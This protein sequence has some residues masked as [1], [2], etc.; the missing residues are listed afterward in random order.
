MQSCLFFLQGRS[1][2]N[3][4]I[5]DYLTVSTNGGR[6]W[7]RRHFEVHEGGVLFSFRGKEVNNDVY[8]RVINLATCSVDRKPFNF[9]DL[10][11]TPNVNECF[12]NIDYGNFLQDISPVCSVPLFMCKV[13]MNLSSATRTYDYLA[14]S[15]SGKYNQR[16]TLHLSTF[17]EKYT[18]RMETQAKL[19]R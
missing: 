7:H 11:I 6:N 18:F 1:R 3:C 19:L 8:Q 13:K 9:A 17:C 5:G 15:P 12:I 16:Y 10:S 2:D 14:T 4:I